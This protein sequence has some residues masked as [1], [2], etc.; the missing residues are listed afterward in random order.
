MP[1]GRK[2]VLLELYREL[3]C[4]FSVQ[5][6]PHA[7]LSALSTEYPR[8]GPHLGDPG[9][10]LRVTGTHRVDDLEPLGC[11]LHAIRIYAVC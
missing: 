9:V 7:V 4:V 8:P 11:A 3:Y 2:T 1:I 5:S 10:P 6:N